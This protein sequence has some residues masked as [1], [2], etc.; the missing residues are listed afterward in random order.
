ML[1]LNKYVKVKS[2]WYF[3]LQVSF[4]AVVV[5]AVTITIHIFHLG[6]LILS[7]LIFLEK[8]LNV[9]HCHYF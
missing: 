5:A 4:V 7:T 6:K 2:F 3:H 8:K 1:D 9:S